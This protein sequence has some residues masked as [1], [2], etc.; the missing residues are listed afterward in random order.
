MLGARLVH[1]VQ[2]NIYL[3]FSQCSASV[4]CTRLK[5]F[6]EHEWSSDGL[7]INSGSK[8]NVPGLVPMVVT[9]A[10]TSYNSLDSL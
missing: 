1:F 6:Y 8:V 7:A 4:N 10:E 2:Y 3:Y 5:R 9:Y